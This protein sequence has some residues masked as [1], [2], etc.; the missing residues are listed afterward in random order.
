MLRRAHSA[1][2]RVDPGARVLGVSGGSAGRSRAPGGPVGL[3]E[4]VRELAVLRPPMHAVSQHLYPRLGP[5]ESRAMPSYLRLPELVR[6]LDRLAPGAP[7]LVTEM[8]WLTQ[9]SPHKVGYVEESTQARFLTDAVRELRRHPRVR[10]AVWFNL[11]D[12]VDWP[13]GLWRDGGGPKPAWDAFRMLSTGA[14]P[15]HDGRAPG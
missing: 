5:S 12:N 13:A 6:E 11:E 10:L 8:G 15:S 7:L 2:T 14:P 9:P 3:V 4:F 1:V